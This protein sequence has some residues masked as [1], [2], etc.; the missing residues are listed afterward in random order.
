MLQPCDEAVIQSGAAT[1]PCRAESARWIL[2]ASIL[3]SSMAFIDGT[4]VNVALPALQTSLHSTVAD[5]QW[6]VESYSLVLSA[7]ILVGGAMGDAAGRRLIFLLGTA[8][9]AAASL[10][11]GISST[12]GQLIVSRSVQGIGAAA[13]IPNSLAI[14][15]ASFS[16]AD[17]GRAIGT[18]SAFTAI[19]TALGPVLGGWLIARGSWHWVFLINLPLAAAVIA[20]SLIHVPESRHPQAGKV[21]L[22]GAA[23]AMLSL[24]GLS[25]GFI[26][27]A[28]RGWTNPWVFG[29]LIGGVAFLVFFIFIEKHVARPM[30]PL[31]LFKSR[32]FSGA[33]LL[34]FLLYAALGIFFFLYPLNLI[35][36]QRYST[37]ATGAAATPMILLMFALSRWS[38]GLINRFGPR[39][40]LIAGP[41]IAAAG[42]LLFAVPSLGGSYWTSFFPA[43]VVLGLGMAVTVAPLTTVVMDS[44]GRERAGVASGINNATSRVAGVLAIAVLG[45]VMQQAFGYK[46]LGLLHHMQLPANV[47]SDIQSDLVKLGGLQPPGNLDPATASRVQIDIFKSFVFGF[48]LIMGICTGLAAASAW[49]AFR[50]IAPRPARTELPASS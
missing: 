20:I 4:V 31:D 19:T 50:M 3:A 36:V 16:D 40:P 35:Q 18:W 6:V 27:S 21:D 34:T 5:V 17:R 42:F 29:S 15:S 33:N 49:V 41:L 38:G 23:A 39:R 45:I 9:F 25:Y 14:L 44:V 30:M 8:L 22:L 28:T 12:I 10:A 24:A 1:A 46:L 47:L 13:M 43:F 11:C 26:E 7:L 32:T 48:R 2:A 37:T